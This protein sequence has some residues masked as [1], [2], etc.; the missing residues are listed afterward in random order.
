M[1][2]P[3][4]SIVIPTRDR[5]DTLH[6]ALKA[7]CA[8]RCDDVEFIVQDNAS[9]PE[10]KAIIESFSDPR[11]IYRRSDKRLSM[12]A[13]FEEGVAATRGDYI[14]IIGDDDAF[15]DGAIDWTVKFLKEH[16]PD[17]MRWSLVPYY[18]PNLCEQNTGFFWLKMDTYH[19]GWSWRQTS[20]LARNIA[21]ANIAG[22]E[23]SM[24]IYHG[25][26]SRHVY[27]QMRSRTGGTFFQYHV[28]DA[29]VHIVMPFIQGPG[30]TGRYIVMEHPLTIY[31]LSG[32]SSGQSW[33]WADAEK[34]GENSPVGK[35]KR[36]AAS[37]DRIASSLQTSIRSLQYHN[38]AV[39]DLAGKLGLVDPKSI[40]VDAWIEV[41][42]KEVRGSPF[43]VTGYLESEPIYDFDKKLFSRLRKE[44]KSILRAPPAAPPRLQTLHDDWAGWHQ[45]PL[46]YIWPQLNDDVD[47]A[48]AACAQLIGNEIGLKAAD[49]IPKG[50]VQAARDQMK[51]QLR[52]LHGRSAEQQEHV[53]KILQG[54]LIEA[55]VLP[56]ASGPPVVQGKAFGSSITRLRALIN[57]ITT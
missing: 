13:N 34:R 14:T 36:E 53:T 54:S 35:W 42:L 18:W 32:H 39:L 2:Q 22:A 37:D 5:P 9:G 19:G 10:T 47:G 28:P 41:I 48:V 1:G 30:I 6:V 40:D 29:Y 26:V 15:C 3:F 55:E 16:R 21:R 12:R 20:D 27:E 49:A 50:Q 33:Y 46:R 25:A 24:L 52:L 56:E 31:G 57:R 11:I 7:I 45:L 4:Y 38:L 17:G 23:E 8:Q 43:Q 51:K 44:H